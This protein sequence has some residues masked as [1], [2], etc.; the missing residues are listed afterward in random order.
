LSELQLAS[1]VPSSAEQATIRRVFMAVL[2]EA[3][4]EAGSRNP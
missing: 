2:L 3:S 4:K 1:S